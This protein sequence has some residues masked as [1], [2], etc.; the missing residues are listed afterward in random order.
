MRT[1][2]QTATERAAL[3]LARVALV[4]VS[5]KL[6]DAERNLSRGIV[7]IATH[8]GAVFVVHPTIDGP[9]YRIAG[10]GR[11]YMSGCSCGTWGD[12]AETTW[13]DAVRH[14]L[15]HAMSSFGG[16]RWQNGASASIVLEATE[17]HEWEEA[18][19]A[20]YRIE[21]AQA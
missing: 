16:I 10:S 17:A 6:A 19:R 8:D 15:K 18:W 2:D 3:R 14:A 13:R 1:R 5:P 21:Q 12:D 7:V 20:K 4:E 11:S 9:M